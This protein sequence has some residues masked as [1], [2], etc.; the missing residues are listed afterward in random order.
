M[1]RSRTAPRKTYRYS[2]FFFAALFA[3]AIVA[4]YPSSTAQAKKTKKANYG[5]IRIQ[6]DPAGLPVEVDGKSHGQTTSGYTVIE[7]L[8]PGVHRV[9]ITLPD[10]QQWIRNIDLPA[11][12]IKCVFINYRPSTPPA[13]T[14][15]PFPVKISAPAQVSEGEVITYSGAAT[16]GGPASL[17][18]TWTVSPANAKVISGNGTSAILVDS[19]GLA[20]QR[21]TATLV[22]DDGS[23]DPRCRA[24]AQFST[25]VPPHQQRERVGNQFD[26]CCGCTSDDQKARLDNLAVELQNDP[27]T[28]AYLIGY[29]G[30]GSRGPQAARLLSQARDYLVVHRGVNESRIVLMDGGVRQQNCIE[31]WI[32]PQ[33][34]TP[35]KATPMP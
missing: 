35:P 19:T 26:V 22:V 18:Y 32:V 14:F 33:G 2:R 20:G 8:E 12:R 10:G 15:C 1:L 5:T 34:A 11:G 6:T 29:S 23:G 7:G 16:Y 3:V 24:V 17:L 25:F 31:I 27:S 4:A 28:T 21:I 9:V 30:R 13:K